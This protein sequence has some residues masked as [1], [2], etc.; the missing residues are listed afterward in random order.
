MMNNAVNKIINTLKPS[1]CHPHLNV[2]VPNWTSVQGLYE[3]K[4]DISC[5]SEKVFRQLPPNHRPKKLE[6]DTTPKLK[7]AGGQPLP[8]R[9]RYEFNTRIDTKFQ[10]HEFYVIADLNEPIILGIDFIQK[11]QLWYCLKNRSFA[12]KG[13][14][15]CGQGHLKI[16]SATTILP[17]SVAFIRA[18]VRTEGGALPEGNLCITN[19]ASRVQPLVTGGPYLV[20]SHNQ[21]QI[22]IAVK[23]CSPFDLNP[24]RNDF[25]R[26]VE[27]LQDCETLEINP[28]Y[29]QAVAQQCKAKQP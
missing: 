10:T 25:I 14:P 12:W 8:V 18:T 13:L 3:T 9:G 4:A 1:F 17:R 7:L 28:A 29:L 22:T 5:L 11:H 21:G 15:N 24:E 23:K 27:N 19:V 20:Q 16:S 6:G 2:S 26:C